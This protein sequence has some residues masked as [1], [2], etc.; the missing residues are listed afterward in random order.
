ML[1]MVDSPSDNYIIDGGKDS[2]EDEGAGDVGDP[3]LVG[4]DTAD[5]GEDGK[6]EHDEV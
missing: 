2:R 1:G 3:V 5:R 6:D 4:E